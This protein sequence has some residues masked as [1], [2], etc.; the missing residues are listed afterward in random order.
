M[1]Q[2]EAQRKR[3]T[4]ICKEV[5]DGEMPG[6]AYTLLHPHAKLSPSSVTAVCTWTK[7]TAQSLS[8]TKI[9]E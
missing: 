8:A 2:Q 4:E 7:D 1:Y 9:E 6:S 5:S 3:L